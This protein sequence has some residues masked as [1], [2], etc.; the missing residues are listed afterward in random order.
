MFIFSFF[1]AQGQCFLCN[2]TRHHKA[3]MC[4]VF[5]LKELDEQ[6]IICTYICIYTYTIGLSNS[7]MFILSYYCVFFSFWFSIITV[8]RNNAQEFQCTWTCTCAN[9]KK[10]PFCSILCTQPHWYTKQL[11][12]HISISGDDRTLSCTGNLRC[13]KW[14][15]PCSCSV[16]LTTFSDTQLFCLTNWGLFVRRSII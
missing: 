1:E 2:K 5:N 12:S 6:P 8:T 16:L 13:T 9:G 15:V 4:N 14:R 11:W 7:T 10:A 3:V